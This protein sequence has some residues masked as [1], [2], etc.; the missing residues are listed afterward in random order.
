MKP[1]MFVVNGEEV[2][3]RVAS[4]QPLHAVV[5]EALAKSKNTGR[6]AAE[7][8]LRH[9]LGQIVADQSKSVSEYDFAHGERLYLTLRV[10]AGG[11]RS[12]RP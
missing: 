8:E 5:K 4:D 1:L 12:V 6:S 11:E 7:W 10:S 3:L 2:V 9:E